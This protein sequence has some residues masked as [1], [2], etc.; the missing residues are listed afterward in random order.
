MPRILGAETSMSHSLPVLESGL[1]GPRHNPAQ[2]GVEAKSL[3]LKAVGN[4]L[5]RG[6]LKFCVPLRISGLQSLFFCF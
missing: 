5:R 2:G 4:V 3:L 6:M 1:L